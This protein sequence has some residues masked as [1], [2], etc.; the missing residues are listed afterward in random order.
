LRWYAEEVQGRAPIQI[1][2]EVRGE[3]GPAPSAVSTALFRIAQEAITNAVRH[4]RGT[5]AKVG[6]EY[7]PGA[8]RLWVEDNGR[9]FDAGAEPQAGSWGLVGIEERA[10]LLGGRLRVTSAAGQG[11]RIEVTIP[12]AEEDGVTNVDTSAARG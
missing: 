10:R 9:G 6:L 2:V 7:G 4:S 1:Q 5:C 11:A 12:Y 8:V 3:A